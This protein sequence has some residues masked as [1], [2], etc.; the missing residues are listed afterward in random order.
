[1]QLEMQWRLRF[2]I[3]DKSPVMLRPLA[4][5]RTSSFLWSHGHLGL[6]FPGLTREPWQFTGRS[7]GF[8]EPAA[9]T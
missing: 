7:L 1:M 9:L 6:R 5:K 2:C 8:R 3:C 4:R